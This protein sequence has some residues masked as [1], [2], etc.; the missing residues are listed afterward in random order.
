MTVIETATPAVRETRALAPAAKP[1]LEVRGLQ[2]HFPIT[3]GV[4]MH[5]RIGDVKAVD[6]VDLNLE[7]RLPRTES[8]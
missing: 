3:E 8:A 2:M 6:G 4:I 5:R 1:L 7:D